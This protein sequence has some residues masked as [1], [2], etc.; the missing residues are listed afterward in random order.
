VILL[1]FSISL[2]FAKQV[3]IPI[4]GTYDVPGGVVE[5]PVEEKVT[6]E[7]DY[8]D[9]SDEVTYYYVGGKLLALEDESGKLTDYFQDRLYNNRLIV[10][11]GRLS[12]E[13]KSLPFGQELKNTAQARF[14]FSGKEL[15]QDLYYF[16]A[17]YYD[18]DLGKFVEVDPVEDDYPYSF[19]HNNPM[20]LVDPTGEFA[21]SV[22]WGGSEEDFNNWFSN[23]F[24]QGLD[25]MGTQQ[26]SYWLP[27]QAG[28]SLSYGAGSQSYLSDYVDPAGQG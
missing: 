11:N 19:T 2:V 22:P 17:R 5:P 9:F 7:G 3:S 28:G 27:K 20:N 14:S 8:P 12:G 23:E 4:E 13:I 24:S 1:I 16:D 21:S 18:S 15:D 10:E 25:V 26:Y 6:I